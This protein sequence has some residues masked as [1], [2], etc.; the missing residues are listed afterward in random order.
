MRSNH[1]VLGLTSLINA[2]LL[3]HDPNDCQYICPPKL[4]SLDLFHITVL[5]SILS[6]FDTLTMNTQTNTCQ[7]PVPT[8]P[9]STCPS[10]ELKPRRERKP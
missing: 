7:I 1:E 4:T 10:L 5:L 2:D 9:V 3:R 8:L 6:C